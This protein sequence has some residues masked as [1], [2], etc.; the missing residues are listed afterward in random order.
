MTMIL[1]GNDLRVNTIF[2]TQPIRDFELCSGD[3]L[4]VQGGVATG[5]TALGLALSGISSE[6]LSGGQITRRPDTIWNKSYVPTRPD[7]MFSGLVETVEKEIGLF[8][9]DEQGAPNGAAHLMKMFGI[10]HLSIRHPMTLSGGERAKVA[11]ACAAAQKPSILFADQVIDWMDSDSRLI[12]Y[13]ALQTLRNTGT[14]VVDSITDRAAAHCGN[15]HI[16][17]VDLREPKSGEVACGAYPTRKVRLAAK[18]TSSGYGEDAFFLRDVSLNMQSGDCVAV[19]GKNGAGKTT[20]LRSLALL[21][22]EM[23]ATIKIEDELVPTRSLSNEAVKRK[24]HLWAHACLYC[25]Q[26]PDDQLFCATVREELLFTARLNLNA[27]PLNVEALATRF[28]LSSVLDTSPIALPRGLR[29]AVLLASCFMA[30][31]PV[32][33]LDEPTAELGRKEYD[34]LVLEIG[35]YIRAGGIC[36]FVSHDGKFVAQMNPRR[37]ELCDGKIVMDRSNR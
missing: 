23:Q 22:P 1:K 32:L 33:L 21:M 7:L 19:L 17:M 12:A 30:N 14:I 9:V 28:G 16:N 2:G 6:G 35:S 24:K 11:L 31:P 13:A 26:E 37:I 15:H 4:S 27:I 5:K 29:R 34:A 25:F 20:L 36:V 10:D 18:I 8:A 3:W